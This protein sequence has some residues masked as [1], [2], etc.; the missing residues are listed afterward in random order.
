MADA[1][2][3]FAQAIAFIEDAIAALENSEP[4]SFIELHNV[5]TWSLDF[6][7][8]TIEINSPSI[9]NGREKR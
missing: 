7:K 9:A 6:A 5:L 8:T 2:L 3:D 1:D 4:S